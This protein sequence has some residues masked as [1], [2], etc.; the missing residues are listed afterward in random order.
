[1]AQWTS[2]GRGI[3][4][5]EHETRKHGKRPDRYW[6]IQYK[7]KGKTINE[8][9]GWWSQGASHAECENLL[10]KLRENWRS[11]QGPQTLKEMRE[12]AAIAKSDEQHRQRLT[13]NENVTVAEFWNEKYYPHIQLYK[14]ANSVR[15]EQLLFNKWLNP[16]AGLCLRDLRKEHI[17]TKV[18]RPLLEAGRSPRT[19]EYSLAVISQ[20]WNMAH[21]Y[22]MVGGDN[23]V[24]KIKK[25]RKDN[26]RDRFLTEEEAKK[27]LAALKTRAPDVHDLSVLSLFTGL[28][29]DECLSLTWADV[30]MEQ[31]RIF[32]KDTK[33]TRN[34]H[35]Y[36]TSEVEEMFRSRYK[37]QRADALVF[38]NSN[39]Q[40]NEWGVPDSFTRTVADSGLNEGIS[41]SRQK[42]VFHTLRHTFASWL[43]QRGVPLY[44]VSKLMG[45]RSLQMTMRYAHLA[46][47]SQKNAAMMLDGALS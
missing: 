10:S 20:M 7:L 39:G 36:M 14:S 12:A 16:L 37:K 46:P 35:A 17:E 42:V 6:C 44:N 25:P 28:R 32:V 47:D 19:V 8:A 9:V 26:K 33:N 1:M 45:H 29:A 31:K 43:V 38:P 24:S 11:G 21:E 15:T 27:L 30:D 23:P 2:A 22:E 40:K 4:Y 13:E 5:R 34:R 3:R 18:V 41:D